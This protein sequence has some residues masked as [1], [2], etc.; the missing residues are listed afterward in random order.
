MAHVEGFQ[1]SPADVTAARLMKN[2]LAPV[3]KQAFE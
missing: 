1:R 3:I 2:G